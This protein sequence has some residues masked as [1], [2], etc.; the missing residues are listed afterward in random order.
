[1]QPFPTVSRPF[2]NVAVLKV[3]GHYSMPDFPAMGIEWART[4][5]KIPSIHIE[6]FA[7][8]CPAL[9]DNFVF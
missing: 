4:I 2:N 6:K 8:I 3:V 9:L 7:T 1:L 5:S